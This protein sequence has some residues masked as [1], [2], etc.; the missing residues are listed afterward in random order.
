[1]LAFLTAG[2]T[3][4]ARRR[5]GAQCPDSGCQ[6]RRAQCL[7]GVASETAADFHYSLEAGAE[8][9]LQSILEPAGVA[10]GSVP[11]LLQTLVAGK[12]RRLPSERQHGIGIGRR[13]LGS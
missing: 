4:T 13:G 10:Q 9:T 12:L 11:N 1:M 8:E 6:K 2:R 3:W 7:P 5:S